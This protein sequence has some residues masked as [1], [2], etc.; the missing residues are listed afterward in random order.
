MTTYR[1]RAGA[2]LRNNVL[3][4]SSTALV[5]LVVSGAAN[6][7]SA[8]PN[9]ALDIAQATAPNFALNITQ[10][11]A[12]DFAVD[13]P[14]SATQESQNSFRLPTPVAPEPQVVIANP[15]TPDTAV[16][17]NDVTGIGQMIIDQQNGYVGL[18]TGTLINPRTVLFAA[19]CV[20]EEAATDYGA[21]SGGKP[22]GFGFGVNNNTSPTYAFGDW[23]N[24]GYTTDVSAAMYNAEYVAYNPGSLE[25]EAQSF[26]YS[27]VALAGLDTPAAGIPTWTLLFSALPAPDGEPTAAGTGYH[28]QIQGYGT[29]G[30][31]EAGA[32]AG[33]DYRR[34]VAENML[35]ALTN[36]DTF[37]TFLNSPSNGLYQNLYFLDFDDPRRGTA[38]ANPYDINAFRD[39]ATPH[40]GITAPGDSGGPLILDDTFNR[41]V[42][43]GVLSGGYPTIYGGAPY[44]Y[45]AVNF[46]QPLYLYW[47]WI[48]ANNPYHYASAKAGDG[49]WSDPDHW[50]TTIDPNY[51]VIDENGNLVTGL[52]ATPGEGVNGTDG[53]FGQICVEGPL[54]GGVSDCLDVS[55]GNETVVYPTTGTGDFSNDKGTA[56]TASL[57]SGDDNVATAP[58]RTA[59]ADEQAPAL[60]DPTLANGLPGATGFVPNNADG[61]RISGTAPRYFDV[62]L[63]AAGTT[64]LDQAVTIDR[65]TVANAEAAL[66][67]G[68]DGSLTSLMDITQY[69]GMMRVNGTLSTNGDYF[70][71]SGGLQGS[72]T[73]NTP[74]F[75]SMAGVI[76]PGGVGTV[77]TLTFNGNIVLT[78]GSTYMVDLGEDGVSDLIAVHATAE[79]QNGEPLN[80][81]AGLGGAVVFTPTEGTL[82]RDGYSYTVIT[83][84]GEVDGTFDMA[85]TAFSAILRP[86]LSYGPNSV[87]VTIEAG[88]YADVIASGA[89]IQSA[90]AQLLDQNRVQYDEYAD[91]YG[92]LD[93]MDAGRIQGTL[94]GLAPR[95]QAAAPAMGTVALDSNA[96]FITQRIARVSQGNSGGTLALYGKPMQM[97]SA[98]TLNPTMAADVAVDASAQPEVRQDVLPEDASAFIA[99]GYIDGHSRGMPTANPYARNEFD[100]FFLA[101]GIE[102]AIGDSGLFGIAFSYTDIDGDAGTPGQSADSH[103]YQLTF[104]SGTTFE[105]GIALDSQ[106]SGGAF[107]VDTRRQVSVGSDS[108]DL[109]ANDTAFALT[110]EV[111]LSKDF[112]AGSSVAFTPRIS[113]RYT[114]IGFT[115]TAER[116]EGPALQYDLGNYDSLQGRA[117]L[118]I[119]AKGGIEPYITGTFVHDFKDKPAAF[120]ANFVGGVGPN[121]L[122]AMPGSDKNWGEIGGGISTSG[123]FMLSAE[124]FTT[125]GRAD[126]EYQTYRA[127]LR[128]AF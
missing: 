56:S 3:L 121:A 104:Y 94:E 109:R 79:D 92:T 41:P 37:E 14:Q 30:T 50:V 124:A 27:D 107:S 78:S 61:D 91:L 48:A 122:F 120:G 87:T 112:G 62:T 23:L 2:R 53:Q 10:G 44:G 96:R 80:G 128:I 85:T 38:T 90:Y 5:C 69:S 100:G 9:F 6:A 98:A 65:F 68:T 64:T 42:V 20:N 60:P 114:R 102:K 58:S 123:R 81:L 66:D 70:L 113:G 22:I 33:S 126:V 63:S 99:G 55:T 29:I 72:G 16:D 54:I 15:G 34:R 28:V 82:L 45:G 75:T 105:N 125:V 7:Q 17:G 35:G 97:A 73:I 101:G 1:S 57:Q 83:A 95:A 31:G 52:P 49:A 77:G 12:P 106:I 93:M 25:P 88:K 119:A 116:G 127:T 71:M 19:H 8:Q 13:V 4:A 51:A 108:Y 39:D 118:T 26:L 47:D 76:A 111:G 36:L 117:G 32:T 18:C 67:I 84:D 21:A 103:L 110:G 40:E 86:E 74:Y 24:G 11:D 59:A 46:Y 89:P 115:P 43:I